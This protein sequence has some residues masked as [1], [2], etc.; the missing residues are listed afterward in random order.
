MVRNEPT[1]VLD[2]SA[3]LVVSKLV[4]DPL[5]LKHLKDDC[6]QPEPYLAN[7]TLIVREPGP[8]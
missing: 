2:E 5:M 7:A 8:K 6:E 1:L 4:P 3:V